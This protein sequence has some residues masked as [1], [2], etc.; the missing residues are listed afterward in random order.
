MQLP[1]RLHSYHHENRKNRKRKRWSPG[2]RSRRW[3][4]AWTAA[5]R[6]MPAIFATICP[7]PQTPKQQETE[8]T[9]HETRDLQAI[10]KTHKTIHQS[11]SIWRCAESF[12]IWKNN[13]RRNFPCL[14]M[15]CLYGLICSW[16]RMK[17]NVSPLIPP[18]PPIPPIL[19]CHVLSISA[20][21]MTCDHCSCPCAC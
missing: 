12:E 2:W 7:A 17:A 21:H 3:S 1:P 19:C 18:I 15:M 16:E 6:N 10:H 13:S 11:Y 8:G 14:A 20:A 4:E 5:L 9:K